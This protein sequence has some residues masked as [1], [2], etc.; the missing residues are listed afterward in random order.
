MAEAILHEAATSGARAAYLLTT[1]AAPFFER[2]GFTRIERADAPPAILTTR[3]ATAL[4]PSTAT[5]L[6]RPLT[7]GSAD[8]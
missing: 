6:A 4:C 2:L 1:T 3:E 5:L 8:D 7:K